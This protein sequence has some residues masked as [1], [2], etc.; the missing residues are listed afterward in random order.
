MTAQNLKIYF[1]CVTNTSDSAGA[2]CVCELRLENAS[3]N[4]N[5]SSSSSP[6]SSSRNNDSLALTGDF[7]VFFS[8]MRGPT[9]SPS[10]PTPTEDPRLSLLV[11]HVNGDLCLFKPANPDAFRLL[12][13]ETATVRFPS[14]Y[15]S[16]AE[17]DA[18]TGFYIAFAD[19][20]TEDLGACEIVPFSRPEQVRRGVRDNVATVLPEVRYA[21][22]EELWR[23]AAR[24]SRE[25]ICPITPKPKS[26]RCESGPAF[27]LG[28]GESLVVVPSHGLESE[29]G[30]LV[31]TLRAIVKRCNRR[32]TDNDIR[33]TQPDSKEAAS[34]Q[35][36]IRLEFNS[37]SSR[38]SQFANEGY[39]LL[40]SQ[41]GVSIVSGTPAGCFRGIT[42][43]IQLISPADIFSSQ[44][45]SSLVIPAISISD[46]PKFGY[47]GLHLDISRNFHPL[48]TILRVV[49]LLALYKFSVLHFHCTDDEGWR[50]EIP[51]LPE[52]TSFGAMRSHAGVPS[53]GRNPMTLPPAQGSGPFISQPGSGHLSRS[54]FIQLLRYAAR[55][56][57]RVI[58]EIELPGHAR[59]AIRSM[60]HR[61]RRILSEGGSREQAEEFLLSHGQDRSAYSSAQAYNDNVICVAMPGAVKF[62]KH[63]LKELR[64]AYDEAGVAFEMVH[65]G[66]DEVPRG[67]W[68]GDPVVQEK[69]RERGIT[70]RQL[71]DEFWSDVISEAAALGVKQTGG[72]EEIAVADVRGDDGKVQRTINPALLATGNPPVAYA[73]NTVWGGGA[74][75]LGYRLANAGFPIVLSS[76][77]FA[78]LDFAYDKDPKEPGLYWGAFITLREAWDFAPLDLFA[79]PPERNVF[80]NAFRPGAIEKLERLAERGKSNLLGVQAQLW[81]ELVRSR[82]RLEYML[83]PRLLAISERGWSSDPVESFTPEQRNREWTEFATRVGLNEFP[84]LDWFGALSARTGASCGEG[85]LP[86]FYRVPVPG[87]LIDDSGMLRANAELPGVEIRYN[88]Q[89]SEPSLEDPLW[90]GPVKLGSTVG[91]VAVACF[92][93]S[94]RSGR[95]VILERSDLM[96]MD[97]SPGSDVS[98]G[99]SP[100]GPRM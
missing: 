34:S 65:L 84:R 33:L 27:Q 44:T 66:G 63:V 98:M 64:S 73:W 75:D 56:H 62:V 58:P 29:A 5:A 3:N 67:A 79:N 46:E 85:E 32:A 13:G 25:D 37:T 14:S 90:T 7:A 87:A 95:A 99:A 52:L 81:S 31:D 77:P 68:E 70:I 80:G 89:G 39:E 61:A 21:A 24:L 12:P 42:S 92:N 78:Y 6:S 50:I 71:L 40:V 93:S 55:L 94:G 59:A 35:K 51:G 16:I 38:G 76:A 43:L 41:S 48:S 72:W 11:Q 96:D 36:T 20:R 83:M 97:R 53:E 28:I 69:L 8:W 17:T 49:D 54:E 23:G 4:G 1:E 30:Y 86:W 26:W 74:E 100:A 9:P 2:P 19:G 57:I 22:H 60:E 18:P 91:K 10:V 82:E 15:F 45:P 88:L 47:R